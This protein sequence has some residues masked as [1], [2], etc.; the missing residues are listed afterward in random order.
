MSIVQLIETDFGA[1]SALA[2]LLARRRVTVQR[3]AAVAV[4]PVMAGAGIAAL[5]LSA[6]KEAAMG[7]LRTLTEA[8]RA[9]SGAPR[10]LIVVEEN[11]ERLSVTS[12]LGGRLVR[13][14]LPAG[15]ADAS[16]L[17]D[18]GLLTLAD[19]IGQQVSAMVA[20][21]AVTGQLIDLA[22]RVARSD[23]TVFINGPTGSG[24]EVLAR[25]IHAASRRKDQPFVAINCAAIPENMLEAIL[26]GHEK[27]AFTGAAGANKGLIRAADG[28]TLLLDEV[29]EMPMGLQSKLL[30]VL[31]ERRVT[32]IGSQTEVPVDIR[33]I[34][35]SNRDMAEEVRANRFREDLYYRLNVFPL[36]TRALA[37][38]PDDI[39]ALAVALIRRHA[40]TEPL[41][42]L[43]ADALS[44][45]QGHAW[46]G[47]V[48]ELE[49]VIQR[50]LVLAEGG[51]IT[52][53]DIILDVRQAQMFRPM[54]AAV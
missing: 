30:R 39:A 3:V 42:M 46:P 19:V 8:V 13:V 37:E 6:K 52:A 53:A 14:A 45:L 48:R 10:M 16:V 27:G 21:D 25:Q 41:P 33:I 7:G 26:F 49:N 43:G 38:R 5:V 15:R 40:R 31:Q 35:T 22:N 50:A 17:K 34:A 36:S 20:S 2:Q 18:C 1:A 28:G 54:L 51:H 12:E 29:S 11:A 4:V 9:R 44:L 23:V 32:P 47:N 24:K